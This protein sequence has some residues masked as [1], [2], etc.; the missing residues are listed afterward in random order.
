MRKRRIRYQSCI[1]CILIAVLLA[2]NV[3]MAQASEQRTQAE[4]T[5]QTGQEVPPENGAEEQVPDGNIKNGLE[6][7]ILN[8]TSTYTKITVK[9]KKIAGAAGYRIYRSTKKNSGYKMLKN[10][11]SG[12][13]VSY[14][15]KDVKFNKTYYYK[16]RAYRKEDGKKKYGPYSEVL[17]QKVMV[18]APKVTQAKCLT[19]K[20]AVVKWKKTAGA[21]GYVIYR[22]TSPNGTY[23]KVG[24][25]GQYTTSFTD[26]KLKHGT[27][28]Y[29]KVRA[30]RKTGRKKR[31]GE[32]SEVR[33]ET[34]G[35]DM[36]MKWMFPDGTPKKKK[37]MEKYL[38]TI[39][40]PIIDDLGNES[41]ME[42][43][44]HKSLAQDI[45]DIFQEMKDIGFPVRSADT[46]A[47]KWRKMSTS[48]SRSHHSYGCVV[49]LNWDSNPMKGVTEGKYRPGVDPYSVTPEVVSIWKSHG[50]YWGGNWKSTKDYM[51]FTYT[52]H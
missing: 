27:K 7:P 22:S 26:K 9:W 52:N 36:R 4:E 8:S 41:T 14:N 50:F 12:S 23:K 19:M 11:S 18:A 28:Y 48:S 49:D 15:D 42:L 3:P 2:C 40:V 39:E 34:I 25:A 10:I 16:V 32:Y 1:A 38:V 21:Q 13:T 17:K 6:A 29:Y 24:T 46:K 20:S 44:V 5:T 51:H 33:Q 37:Q 30:Y 43:E 35:L 31:Y 45:K 47:Y